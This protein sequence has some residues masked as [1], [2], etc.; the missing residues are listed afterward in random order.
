MSKTLQIKILTSLQDKLSAP[1]NRIRGATGTSGQSIKDLRDRLKTLESTQKEVGQFRGLS[2]GLGDT[3]TKLEAA[4][5]RANQLGTQ[6][7]STANPSA[8]L[9]REFQQASNQAGA[10]KQQ[11][12]AQAQ[13][14]QQLRSRLSAA[15]LSTRDLSAGERQL[16]SD[17]GQTN[18]ALKQQQDRLSRVA[19]Q[20][21]KLDQAKSKYQKTQALAG[22][23]SAA[24]AA[25]VATG[26][27][28]LYAGARFMGT[29]IEFDQ[30]MSQVQALARLDKNGPEM[31]ALRAQARKLGA[32]TQFTAMDAAAGQGFLAMAGFDPKAIQAA[33]PGMLDI[34]KAGGMELAQTADIASN[35]LTGFKIDPSQMGRVGDVLVGTFTRSNVDLTMLGETM[36]YAAPIAANLGQDIET[37]AAMAGKLG[38]AGIQGGMAGTAMRSILNRMSAPPKAAADAMKKLGLRTADS[39]GNLRPMPELLTEIY[40]KTKNMGNTK[41]ADLLKAIAGEEA[42]SALQIL[43]GQAGEGALQAFIETLK[44]TQ[45]EASATAKTMAD[46]MAGDI[47]AMKSAWQDLGIGIQEQQD[48]VLRDLVQR[49]TGIIRSVSDWANENPELVSTLVRVVAVVAALIAAGGALTLTMASVLAPLAIL[50]YSLTVLGIK[51]G[52]AIGVLWN[53]GKRV[54]PF[55]GKAFMAL[56]RLMLANPIGLII[57]GIAAAGYLIYRYWEPISAF[58]SNLW[59]RIKEAFNGGIAGISTLLIN[60]SPMGLIYAAFAKVMSY[61]GIELPA[62]FTQFGMGLLNSF[63][64]GLQ[65]AWQSVSSFFQQIWGSIQSLFAQGLEAI[66]T[67]ISN[68]SPLALFQQI[69]A[70]VMSF[71]GVELPTKFTEFGSNIVSGLVNGITSMAGA[72]KESISGMG[73]QV[74]GWFKEKLGIQSPSRVFMG[75]GENISEGAAMGISSA[76]PLVTKAITGLSAGLMALGNTVLAAEPIR[77]DTRPAIHTASQPTVPLPSLG[78]SSAPMS[79]DKYE[80]HIHPTPS[81]DSVDITRAVRVELERIE[82]EKAA[83]RRSS[84][85]DY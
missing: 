19:Q 13:T 70:G 65:Q 64:A 46:N 57:T 3:A 67:A 52:G 31:K 81:M 32:E 43:V 79:G 82:R 11:H 36:K 72:V 21:R 12:S 42:V 17:I 6:L 23:M 10:L 77:F 45:G 9:R 56:A 61:F 1:L 37:I 71:F 15:G 24:G 35:I 16:R 2:K 53:L 83:R 73:S 63:S 14:L 38:D 66:G 49:V 59:A 60:W 84:L 22:S 78:A 80:I 55:I 50:R 48:G 41:R 54:I 85:R 75:F 74:M 62:T 20:Q 27:A 8:A 5:Q 29:G 47:D 33:M 68:W 51:G 4:R 25:G 30:S 44:N 18:Q 7:R 76:A 28:T 58:F 69:F 40:E 26:S 34:A 39:M